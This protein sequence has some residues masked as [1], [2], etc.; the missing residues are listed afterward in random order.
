MKRCK[1]C[2]GSKPLGEYYAS[3]AAKDG[4]MRLCK[5]CSNKVSDAWDKA[6]PERYKA[7]GK[8]WR[9]RNPEWV[10]IWGKRNPEKF[11][12]LNLRNNAKSRGIAFSLTLSDIILPKVCPVFG[13]A[14]R[15]EKGRMHAISADRI[16]PKKGYTRGC[17]LYTSPPFSMGPL[18]RGIDPFACAKRKA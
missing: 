11:V 17:L 8:A 16:N 7:R 15:P 14:F 13:T 3:K 18:N 6:H 12:L 10:K 2:R 1:R 4:H 5:L 9:A